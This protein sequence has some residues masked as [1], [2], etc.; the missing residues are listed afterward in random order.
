M[1]CACMTGGA[2]E[3]A[4]P[5]AEAAGFGRSPGGR[6]ATPVAYGAICRATWAVSACR[7]GRRRTYNAGAVAGPRSPSVL[8]RPQAARLAAASRLTAAARRAVTLGR[9]MVVPPLRAGLVPGARPAR[10]WHQ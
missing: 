4:S 10:P 8:L 5:I 3:G 7:L 2:A 1:L 9:R 6:A